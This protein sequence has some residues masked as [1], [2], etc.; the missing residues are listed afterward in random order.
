MQAIDLT[1]RTALVTGAGVR[2]GRAFALGIARAGANVAIHYNQSAE[3]A[4]KT[5]ESVQ[6]Q[7]VQATIVQGDL[8]IAEQAE[9]LLARTAQSLGTVDLLVNSAAIFEPATAHE[10][11]LDVWQRHIDINLRAPVFLT[12]GLAL[13]LDGQPGA[14]VN[15]L[16]WRALRP[17][18]EHF[19]YSIAKAGLAAATQAM[20][21]AYAPN[22][23]V[24]GLALGAILPPPGAGDERDDRIIQNVPQKRWGTVDEAVQALLFLLGGPQYITGELLHLD[25]GRHLV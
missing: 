24:N 9:R 2:L 14:V 17:G 1:G 15:L 10:T 5:A 21:R 19:A 16:D 3:Q 25:G 7:G 6:E 8:A 22:L 13:A 20:A 4:E 23:R 18:R 11:T 12:R